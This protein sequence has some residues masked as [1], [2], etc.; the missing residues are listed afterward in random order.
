MRK[1]RSCSRL[2]LNFSWRQALI[3]AIREAERIQQWL[4]LMV[5][6]DTC[7]M[8]EFCM[9][10]K[11]CTTHY[12]WSPSSSSGH[13][14]SLQGD[15]TKYLCHNCPCVVIRARL[16]T[17]ERD[18]IPALK[19]DRAFLV[20]KDKFDFDNIGQSRKHEGQIYIICADCDSLL[21]Y[22]HEDTYYLATSRVRIAT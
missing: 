20:V 21:G 15:R 17:V 6:P 13:G 16:E 9:N 22:L 11:R 3:S 1:G 8:H 2:R 10:R 19:N 18:S 12:G 4:E 7:H 14:M 5:E